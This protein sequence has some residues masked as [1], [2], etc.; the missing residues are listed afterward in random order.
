M[1]GIYCIANL[2]N[3]KKYVGQSLNISERLIDHFSDLKKNRHICSLM[4]DD[5]NNGHFFTRGVV[6]ESNVLY[7]N[8]D[9]KNCII[10]LNSINN[11]YNKVLPKYKDINFA[12]NEFGKISVYDQETMNLLAVFETLSACSVMMRIHP[13]KIISRL[14]NNT[15]Y[16]NGYIFISEENSKDSYLNYWNEVSE[17]RKFLDNGGREEVCRNNFITAN[18]SKVSKMRESKKYALTQYDLEMNEVE[19]YDIISDIPEEFNKKAV[20]K[21]LQGERKSHKGFIWKYDTWRK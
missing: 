16:W 3:G 19:K 20:R 4:Q 15:P 21:V 14:K 2:T 11:G 9:E 5:Y 12:K 6:M 13:D 1:I 17:H 10:D 18:E 8:R 7:T